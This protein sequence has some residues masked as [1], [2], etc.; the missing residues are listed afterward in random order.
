MLALQF[1][2][3]AKSLEPK[4]SVFEGELRSRKIPT[5]L[6][7]FPALSARQEF[8]NATLV[9]AKNASELYY[10]RA[11]PKVSESMA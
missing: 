11:F 7:W 5:G 1:V 3:R 9:P 2:A 6:K 8:V 4:G 10:W